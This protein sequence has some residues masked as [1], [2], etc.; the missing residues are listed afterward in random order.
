MTIAV[1][2]VRFLARAICVRNEAGDARVSN[3]VAELGAA[4]WR[5]AQAGAGWPAAQAGSRRAA[6]RRTGS[7]RREWA[8]LR[9]Q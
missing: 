9:R 1:D 8:H 2:D 6:S 3:E 7:A 5:V 4:L